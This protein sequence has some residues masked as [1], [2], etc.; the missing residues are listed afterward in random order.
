MTGYPRIS[1]W[2]LIRDFG[3]FGNAFFPFL[4]AA[5][6]EAQKRPNTLCSTTILRQPP[7]SQHSAS[8]HSSRMM[9]ALQESASQ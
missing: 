2:A 3:F 4:Y 6:S 9:G 1:V 5:F 7:Y 8:A